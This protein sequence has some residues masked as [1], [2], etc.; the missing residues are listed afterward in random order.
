MWPIWIWISPALP[1]TSWRHRD[2]VPIRAVNG[3]PVRARNGTLIQ[4]T[5]GKP[6]QTRNTMPVQTLMRVALLLS[7]LT[8][9]A[10]GREDPRTAFVDPA[11]LITAQKELAAKN[12]LYVKA[13]KQ[14]RK[15]ADKALNIVPVSVM[16][17]ERTPPSGD[18]HDYMSM[19]K[20]WWPGP[21]HKEGDP[22]IRKDGEVNPEAAML[23]DHD[24]FG[25]LAKAVQVLSL[26][27][28]FTTNEEY[29]EHA[30]RL[31]RVWFLDPATRMNPNLNYAQGIPGL[32]KGRGF[33][34]IDLRPISLVLDGI[35]LIA[36]SPAWTA[37]DQNGMVTW[38]RA[39][40]TWLRESP[41]GIQE[42]NASNNHG[43]WY[44]VQVLSVAM[45][46]Q[47]VKLAR[48]VA[49]EAKTMRIA[50][51]I[52]PDGRQMEELARTRS[53][54]YSAM[55]V[56]GMFALAGLAQ[57]AGV[58][59]WHFETPDGRSIRRALDYL[60]PFALGEKK[61]ATQEIRAF[62]PGLLHDCLRTAARMYGD[63]KYRDAA[64]ALVSED[65]QNARSIVLYPVTL[66][67]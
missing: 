41:N 58:D 48:E 49:G 66:T 16:E 27:Y 24:N 3:K 21:D 42:R 6:M 56:E 38:C 14:I 32:E 39:Y 8:T 44:D 59:L 62:E 46:V 61:W 17:K 20:Y 57:R 63:D 12:S 53:W 22:Y 19:G 50:A 54:G 25:R 35:A 67:P 11:A 33:G 5:D 13:V 7:L 36:G 4:A 2:G 1:C 64:R 43:T 37:G 10:V 23:P 40:L 47:D 65:K 52:E 29:A 18:K 9:M 26:G 55:N 30:A 15:E 28:F 34:I 51:Q 45:F 60:L 31:L